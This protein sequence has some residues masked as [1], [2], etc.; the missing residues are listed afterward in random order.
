M[1]DIFKYIYI[2][3]II[4]IAIE[5]V[6]LITKLTSL[7]KELDKLG[8]EL[9]SIEKNLDKVKAHLKAIEETKD[10]WKFFLSLYLIL[11]IIKMAAKEFRKSKKANKNVS[12]ASTLAKVCVKNIN[13]I[14]KIKIV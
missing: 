1:N 14:S 4:A 8:I 11:S 7:K 12:F 10:S 6:Y 5:L 13:T 3:L 9:D 2:I